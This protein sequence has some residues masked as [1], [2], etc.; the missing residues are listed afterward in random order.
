[1]E[2]DLQKSRKQVQLLEA[3]L[4]E[5]DSQ[6]A[7]V[8]H[9][10]EVNMANIEQLHEQIKASQSDVERLKMVEVELLQLQAQLKHSQTHVS[11]RKTGLPQYT[12]LYNKFQ[13]SFRN[14]V[15]L[16]SDRGFGR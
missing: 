7:C 13:F 15:F 11:T 4:K 1:M 8:R 16:I 12:C 5:K 9:E 3:E 10:Q 6:L 14:I 2:E